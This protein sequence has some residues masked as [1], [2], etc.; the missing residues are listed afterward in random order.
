M[1]KLNQALLAA[2]LGLASWQV[3]AAEVKPEQLFA[4][5]VQVIALN[6]QEMSEVQGAGR[7]GDIW[8][9]FVNKIQG[10]VQGPPAASVVIGGAKDN[11]RG[12]GIDLT[13]MIGITVVK[14]IISQIPR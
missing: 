4:G 11:M 13:S 5:N 10:V 1:K 6:D 9:S 8:R 3:S 14:N 2:A 7:L 12:G